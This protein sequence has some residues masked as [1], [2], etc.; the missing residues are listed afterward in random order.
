[1][2]LIK[3]FVKI[4]IHFRNVEYS[5]YI[6]IYKILININIIQRNFKL[7][8]IKLK[9]NICKQSL[10]NHFSQTHIVKVSQ[11]SIIQTIEKQ[12][13]TNAKWYLLK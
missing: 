2:T 12:L 7:N 3:W 5:N 13:F 10:N 1:M 4:R 11:S 9:K 8:I 6:S